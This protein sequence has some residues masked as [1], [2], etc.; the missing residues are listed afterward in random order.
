MEGLEQDCARYFHMPQ[1]SGRLIPSWASVPE[2]LAF[3]VNIDSAAAGC[4][5]LESMRWCM[6]VHCP[7]QRS[8][9]AKAE[10]LCPS[11]GF[12]VTPCTEHVP[13]WSPQCLEPCI[14][15]VTDI[16]VI[17]CAKQIHKQCSQRQ[18]P[19]IAFIAGI[20]QPSVSGCH[21]RYFWRCSV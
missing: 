10:D 13:K 21:A 18:R 16:W 19:C 5:R 14:A 4:N 9:D 15:S 17:H 20:Q 8:T 1:A 6:S 12:W 2:G 7:L 11:R 3:A